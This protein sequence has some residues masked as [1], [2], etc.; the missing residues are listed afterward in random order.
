MKSKIKL[1]HW[2]ILIGSTTGALM[3]IWAVIQISLPYVNG[4]L[5]IAAEKADIAEL[6]KEFGE[7][8]KDIDDIKTAVLVGNA[9][10]NETARRVNDIDNMLRKTPVGIAPENL[11]PTASLRLPFDWQDVAFQATTE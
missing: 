7:T 9:L 11:T 5:D 2:A 3:G 10:G 4:P 6:R 1:H 8:R